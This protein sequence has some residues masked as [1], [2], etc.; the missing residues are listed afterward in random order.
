MSDAR[1]S[2]WDQSYLR[3]ENHVFYPH[4]SLVRF[5]NRH[6]R[7]RLGVDTFQD[8]L[9]ARSGGRLR[10]LDFGCGIGAGV[11]LLHEFG[12]EGCGVDISPV[13]IGIAKAFARSRGMDLDGMLSAVEPNQRLP[14]ADGQFDV[15]ISSCVLDSMPFTAARQNM[16]ELARVTSQ[17]GY[18]SL[19][20]GDFIGFY[21]EQVVQT[22]LEQNTI[23]SYFN[24][25]KCQELVAGTGFRIASCEMETS[26]MIGVPASKIGRY[27]LMLQKGA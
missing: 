8:R 5:I 21:G 24:H 14:F 6:V 20:A 26:E 11:I 16:R 3:A 12:I 13:S 25:D 2:E 15:L 9:S 22:P 7:K 17:C 23:Q 1:V 10:A 4:E 18:I 27:H 19:A